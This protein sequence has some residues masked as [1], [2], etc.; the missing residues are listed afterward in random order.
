MCKSSLYIIIIIIIII[1][2]KMSLLVFL[3]MI[4]NESIVLM[5]YTM[6]YIS[7]TVL[8]ITKCVQCISLNSMTCN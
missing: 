4:S 6:R 3:M 7:W 1:I 2:I 8:I 5:N